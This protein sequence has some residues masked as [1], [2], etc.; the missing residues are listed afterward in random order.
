MAAEEAD[1]FENRSEAEL[2][3]LALRLQEALGREDALNGL[4]AEY[5]A[6]VEQDM[7]QAAQ[8]YQR[9]CDLGDQRACSP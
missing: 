8:F 3:S 6:G 4:L 5:G 2:D 9:A 1:Y 7:E